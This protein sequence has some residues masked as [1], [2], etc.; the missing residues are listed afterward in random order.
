MKPT[1]PIVGVPCRHDFS[2]L[3]NQRP[4]YAQSEGYLSAIT[5]AGGIPFLIPLN[6][7][8]PALRRLYDL[9]QGILLPGG[10]DIAPELCYQEPHATL[11]DVQPD[12]DELEITLSRW[13]AAE[14]KPLLGICRGIQVMAVAGG[15]TL[16]QDLPSQMPEA[17]L[18]NYGYLNGNSPTW[19][20]LVHEVRL[21]PD[22]RLAQILQTTSLWVNSLHHQAVQ[23]VA[24]PFAITGRSSDGVVEVIELADHRFWCG[25]QWHPE[26]LLA[27]HVSARRLFEAFIEACQAYSN[28]ME[29]QLV[30]LSQ[31]K[32]NL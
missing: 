13:A 23:N 24:E 9:S 28:E 16:C 18:H 17:K 21:S 8:R 6:L 5:Q 15:G 7:D 30:D 22:S 1:P 11:S 25:V 27:E 10:G 20:D 19:H 14:G 3:Y 32:R 12:R 31:R 2:V 4:V 26:V 29:L